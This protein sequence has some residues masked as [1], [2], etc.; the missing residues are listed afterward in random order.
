MRI[1]AL[2]LLLAATAMPVAADAAIYRFDIHDPDV[3][4][5]GD[6]F[7]DYY[8]F[9][10]SSP[11]PAESDEFSFTLT[12]TTYGD[13]PV[14]GPVAVDDEYTFYTGSAFGGLSTLEN[15]YFG[16]QLFTGT[17]AAPTFLLGT[18]ALDNFGSGATLTISDTTPPVPEPSLWATMVMGF[19][20]TGAI[21]RRR[22][23]RVSA[24]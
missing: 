10:D 20:L 16:S 9:L 17:T 12:G 19:G 2:A 23:E 5:G 18:F 15:I 3:T 6:S 21:M 7:T 4:L 8:F 24:V 22:Q 13:R 11:T 1:L 14:F